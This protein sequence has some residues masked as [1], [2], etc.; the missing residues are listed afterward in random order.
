[1]FYFLGKIGAPEKR[2]FIPANSWNAYR[3]ACHESLTDK[4]T[5]IFV[6]RIQHT[7]EYVLIYTLGFPTWFLIYLSPLTQV[8][9]PYFLAV[10]FAFLD[11]MFSFQAVSGWKA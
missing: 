7:Y 1:L 6:Y 2:Q 4:K 3:E 5:W 9:T 10:D 8:Y 11:G